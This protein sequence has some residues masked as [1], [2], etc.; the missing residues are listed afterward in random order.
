MSKGVIKLE[1]DGVDVEYPVLTADAKSLRSQLV[2]YS[3]GGKLRQDAGSK[4]IVRALHDIS[5]KIEAGDR[6]GLIGRN[7][8]GKSTML[9]LMAGIY[10][11]TKG[12]VK[13][14]GTVSVVLGG[15]IGLSDDV[16]GFEA[17]DYGCRL[18]GL[19]GAEIEEARE[20][21][22][23]FC[24]LGEYLSM[25][26]RTYSSG[27]KVRLSFGIATSVRQDILL[28]DEV[29]GA[30]DAH[31][32]E[33]AKM[34]AI[35]FMDNSSIVVLASHS[36]DIIR[37]ICTRAV[38]LDSGEIIVSGAVEEV[39][40][41]YHQG[42]LDNPTQPA[43]PKGGS[44]LAS[45][46]ADGFGCENAFSGGIRTKWMSKETG[47]AV[48]GKAAIGYDFGE[49]Q[50]VAVR[51]FTL[52]QW[53]G[54]EENNLVTAVQVQCSN[55]GFQDDIQ[56]VT[57]IPVAAVIGRNS[58][59][60][61]SS[62][63]ARYWRLLA[64]SGTDGGRWGVAELAFNQNIE[65]LEVE[66]SHPKWRPICSGYS[67][68]NRSARAFD[69]KNDTFWVSANVNTNKVGDS[70][71]G[72]D[73][74]HGNEIHVRRFGIQQWDYGQ[75]P[76]TV[77]RVKVESS[78]D[79]FVRNINLVDT[80][81]LDRT[82]D[83]Q[84]YDIAASQPARYWRIR[85]DMETGGG[86]WG[87]T[88]LEFS[89][90]PEPVLPR[91]AINRS[92]AFEGSASISYH[93]VEGY[94]PSMAFDGDTSSRWLSPDSGQGVAEVAWIGYDFGVGH[95]VEVNRFAVRQW[96]GG[97]QSNTVPVVALQC[98]DDSFHGDVKTVGVFHLFHN[99]LNNEFHVAETRSARYWRLLA[100]EGTEGG[101]WGVVDLAFWDGNVLLAGALP[102]GHRSF[103][104]GPLPLL[105]PVDD[106]VENSHEWLGVDA[107]ETSL[108]EVRRFG[109]R[110]WLAGVRTR[111]ELTLRLETA[112][113]A[114]FTE[115]LKEIA[116]VR[117]LRQSGWQT[118]NVDQTHS[119]RFW[120][121]V[122]ASP[123]EMGSWGVVDIEFSDVAGRD[124][125]PDA[126]AFMKA[127]VGLA[128]ISYH[129][130]ENHGPNLFLEANPFV[131]WK[132]PDTASDG[133][134]SAWIGYD[135]G[136]GNA[137]E[138]RGFILRQVENCA[139]I[140]GVM[141]VALEYSNDGFLEDVQMVECI[142]LAQGRLDH[143][144]DVKPSRSA[145]YWRIR[146][147]EGVEGKY[148]GVSQ[149]AFWGA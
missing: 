63:K 61:T 30:G 77:G 141:R 66:D 51:Q 94:P 25:P 12:S 3:S 83:F 69:G 21:I 100:L 144:Y 132:S 117:T 33:K 59:E 53:C 109:V 27:M 49:D 75:R 138:V 79:G 82:M 95:A 101:P 145:R 47:Q 78:N 116:T 97:F 126:M 129:H 112:S 10:S 5:L 137:V 133:W 130:A 127:F 4:V 86:K 111:G 107:G 46:Q 36:D 135:F 56:T 52:R 50:E 15:G 110:Q 58:Y 6:I 1:L 11:A 24:E 40:N 8:A 142:D 64:A 102:K 146:A 74:G 41:I 96:V 85:D 54:G 148:W 90:H 136:E 67:A 29:I 89:D 106:D 71:I 108:M 19:R 125:V 62:H 31:F 84:A 60:F 18:M 17:I 43:P 80:V 139:D 121:V 72:Y 44:P 38:L 149:L 2:R 92:H 26:L 114:A 103:G 128:P 57:E 65:H 14:S 119:A 23:E 28:L 35:E 131:Y 113:D 88:A 98:S 120:R 123:L 147:L 143:S 68:P 122:D 87:I 118:F 104:D 32:I 20:Q 37:T 93:H 81:T 99:R 124:D 115:D 42:L 91:G 13:T 134:D 73:F 9:R 105:T 76:N 48:K 39:L 70:W 16:T 140:A 22:V 7:G 34:R 55:D 45:G